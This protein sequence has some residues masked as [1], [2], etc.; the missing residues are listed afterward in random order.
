MDS[1]RANHFGNPLITAKVGGKNTNKA[2][3]SPVGSTFS[4]NDLINSKS[5]NRQSIEHLYLSVGSQGNMLSTPSLAFRHAAPPNTSSSEQ[6]NFSQNESPLLGLS[7]T[8][9]SSTIGLPSH[10]PGSAGHHRINSLE[11]SVLLEELQDFDDIFE[12]GQASSSHNSSTS[13]NND[14]DERELFVSRKQSEDY[15]DDEDDLQ[16]FSR[17]LPTRFSLKHRRNISDLS[18]L[19]LSTPPVGLVETEK[20]ASRSNSWINTS[21]H[22]SASS[23]RSSPSTI[24][25]SRNHRRSRNRALSSTEF[26]N[27]VLDELLP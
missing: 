26:Q 14:E 17:S 10:Y 15:D 25:S 2:P 27:A 23:T 19:S 11:S 22:S 13:D 5:I 6:E 8:T 18:A 7:I 1:P 4:K 24:S 21:T 3:A 16:S 12:Q 20:S 9:A